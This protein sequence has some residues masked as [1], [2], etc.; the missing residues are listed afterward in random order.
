MENVNKIV[1]CLLIRQQ[2][3]RCETASCCLSFPIYFWWAEQTS[4]V[5]HHSPCL[6][7]KWPHAPASSVDIWL[8]QIRDQLPGWGRGGAAYVTWGTVFKTRAAHNKS[9][10]IL[11]GEVAKVGV[12]V[13]NVPAWSRHV[14]VEQ[15]WGGTKKCKGSLHLAT[16]SLLSLI[17]QCW[18]SWWPLGYRMSVSHARNNG[19]VTPY[20]MAL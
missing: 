8:L 3:H 9:R 7:C 17:M 15:V 10:L 5:C 11:Y 13:G 1:S 6:H 4:Q 2:R 12:K 14:W 20:T 19:W 18:A 16:L